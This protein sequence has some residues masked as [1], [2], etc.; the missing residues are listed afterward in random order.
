VELGHC[1]VAS[2]E[3]LTAPNIRRFPVIVGT[4]FGLLVFKRFLKMR[5]TSLI[6]IAVASST[7]RTVLIAFACDSDLIMYLAQVAGLFSGMAQ[8]AIVSF[9]VQVVSVRIALKVFP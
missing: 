2:Q 9:I 8:P 1:S 3:L 4:V 7:A 6:L 5:E